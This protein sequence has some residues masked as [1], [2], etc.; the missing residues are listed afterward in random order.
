MVTGFLTV[1]VVWC[2]LYGRMPMM[3]LL[4][5]C[6]GLGAALPLLG[7]HGSGQFLTIDV[8]AQTSRL[9]RVSPLLKFWTVLVLM[10]LCVSATSPAVGLF[11]TVLMLILTVCGGGLALHDYIHLL[12]LPLSFL[13]LGGLALLLEVTAQKTGVL[14]VPVF[15][16][17]LCVSQA[18]QTRAMLV[19]G[20]ALGSL[21]CLY[22]LSLTTPMSDL[23]G[24]LR[25]LRCPEVLID[26]MYLI[27]RYIF[28]LLSMY[29]AMRDAAA[30]R[31]G[32]VDYRTGMRTTGNLYFG[33]LFRS[34]RQASRNFDAMESRC[35]DSGIRFLEDAGKMKK[36][37]GLASAVLILMTLGLSVLFW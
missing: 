14:G 22:M 16:F 3:I 6:L 23:I 20:R 35:F 21:S 36:A 24:V 31:L 11:L 15:G 33:L 2:L 19:M 5:L 34:Y 10:V 17:W 9:N 25:R 18:A 7:R 27:Y 4:P 12:A 28:I 8:L 30:S 29:H 37:H 1:V 32:F 26:L 13:L